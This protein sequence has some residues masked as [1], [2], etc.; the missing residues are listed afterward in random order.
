[1]NDNFKVLGVGLIALGTVF[2][3]LILAQMWLTPFAPD[4]FARLLVTL[5]VCGIYGIYV[6]MIWDDLEKSRYRNLL[7]SLAGFGLIAVVLVLVQTWM[8]AFAW[9]TFVKLMASVVILSGLVSFIMA[10][11]EDFLEGK[12]LK[13]Q[14]FLD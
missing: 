13:D 11:R 1:M 8:E 2:A 3:L 5:G 10:I 4:F 12:R 9:A 6:G 14:D 7:L